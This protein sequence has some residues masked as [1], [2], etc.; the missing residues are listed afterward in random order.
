MAPEII[1]ILTLMFGGIK[2]VVLENAK[3]EVASKMELLHKIEKNV[4]VKE[5]KD[6]SIDIVVNPKVRI[7]C[8]SGGGNGGRPTTPPPTR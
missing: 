7:K 8:N 6:G 2:L 4:S 3:E 1:I 5:F